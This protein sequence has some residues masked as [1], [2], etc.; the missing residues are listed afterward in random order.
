MPPAIKPSWF[1]VVMPNI[2]PFER[3]AGRYD[4]WFEMH[5]PIYESV[6]RALRTLLPEH[7]EGVEIGAGSARF[8]APLGIKVGLE[9]S[10]KLGELA[11]KRGLEVVKGVAEALPFAQ[12]SFD[13]ALMVTTICFLDDLAAAFREAARVVKPGGALVIGFIAKDS[14]LGRRYE[15]HKADSV[16]YRVATFYTVDEVVF[17]LENA[18]FTCFSFTQTIFHALRE[19]RAVEPVKAGYGE[20]SFVVIKGV[21]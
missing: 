21:H 9:P 13:F 20:G 5:K 16:F 4:A 3:Y 1:L 17:H 7:G 18:G 19:I 11:R 15:Q 12:A 14:P 2:E 6:L 8:A 10:G